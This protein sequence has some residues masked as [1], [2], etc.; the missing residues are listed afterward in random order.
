M[1]VATLAFLAVTAA[2]LAKTRARLIRERNEAGTNAGLGEAVSI[3]RTSRT[4][5]KEQEAPEP[6]RLV[7]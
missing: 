5:A 1:L 2:I 6:S 7:A 3:V 4:V